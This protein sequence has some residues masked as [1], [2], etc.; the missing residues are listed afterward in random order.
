MRRMG[1]R[2]VRRMMDRMG[3]NA[4]EL[5]EVKEVIFRTPTKELV[6]TN[7]SVTALE[8]QGQKIYQVVGEGVEERPLQTP[9]TP[10][11]TPQETILEEDVQLVA[12]QAGVGIEEARGALRESQGDLAKAILLLSGR[13]R[14]K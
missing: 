6:V 11:S 14:G 4:K 3:I 7:P 12:L 13:G 9:P 10:T 8:I 5:P 1:Q 2:D